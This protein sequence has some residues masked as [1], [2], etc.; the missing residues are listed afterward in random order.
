MG[1][2]TSAKKPVRADGS[3]AA[4]SAQALAKNE[5]MNPNL[6]NAIVLA[7]KPIAEV[8]QG[9]NNAVNGITK[10]KNFKIKFVP[11]DDSYYPNKKS[12]VEANMASP[13][14]GPQ[15]SNTLALYTFPAETL[16]RDCILLALN[17][18]SRR[19]LR[20]YNIAKYQGFNLEEK[21]G[22]RLEELVKEG[23]EATEH[24]INLVNSG[25]RNFPLTAREFIEKNTNFYATIN[26]NSENNRELVV[27]EKDPISLNNIKIHNIYDDIFDAEINEII[28]EH[29]TICNGL[30]CFYVSGAG[31]K[32]HSKSFM[33]IKLDA[34]FLGGSGS[35][36]PSKLINP[37]ADMPEELQLHVMIYVPDNYIFVVGGQSTS[38]LASNKVYYYDI[39]NNSWDKHSELKSGRVEHSLCL[40]NDEYLYAF[41]GH[42]NNK[43]ND[44]KT[45]ERISLRIP[46]SKEPVT[47]WEQIFIETFDLSF[48]TLYAVGQYKNS[49]LLLNVDENKETA[50]LED[51]NERNLIFNL[52]TNKLSLYSNEN[53]QLL[54]EN[55]ALPTLTNSKNIL[56]DDKKSESYKLDFF[57]RA[58]VP[59]ADNILVLS[60]YNHN[61][62]K[63]NL[64]IIKD[65][66]AMNEPFSHQI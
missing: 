31:I 66:V 45:I 8:Q 9:V 59:I 33:R 11:L 50:E 34:G 41:F 63:T 44:E 6:Q 60:P 49:I 47:V 4:L 35:M 52:H 15:D 32:G 14:K 38:E 26:Y 43:G 28:N 5:N 24:V 25:L 1:N 2:C 42:K 39:K 58:F 48:F 21:M 46:I 12:S 62:E 29:T 3:K 27:F 18:P 54:K 19:N 30:N 57:E 17:D 55:K 16:L 7:Q 56:G 22:F 61:K 37:L 64:V 13:V 10:I 20:H 51:N 53:I 36:P 65:G 23:D 40:V